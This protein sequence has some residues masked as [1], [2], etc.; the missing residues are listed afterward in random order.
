[1]KRLHKGVYVARPD[2]GWTQITPWVQDYTIDRGDVS[3]LGTE[4]AGVDSVVKTLR[5]TLVNEKNDTDWI[6][7]APED[8]QSDMNKDSEEAY[9]PLLS[10]MREII[11]YECITDLDEDPPEDYDDWTIMFHGFLGDDV[12]V[13]RDTVEI[14]ARDKAKRLQ[15]AYVIDRTE[16]RIVEEVVDAG[17]TWAETE[18]QEDPADV[19]EVIFEVGAGDLE[20]LK[21]IR[22]VV[23]RYIAMPEPDDA[24]E[25]SWDFY[26]LDE[27]DGTNWVHFDTGSFVGPQ[28]GAGVMTDIILPALTFIPY[29][30][31]AVFTTGIDYGYVSCNIH[32]NTIIEEEREVL[33]TYPKSEED[34]PVWDV[35]QDVIDDTLGPGEVIVYSPSGTS[36]TPINPDDFGEYIPMVYYPEDEDELWG[37]EYETV[38]NAIQSVATQYG[39]Y[40]G[41]MY[42]PNTS[43]EQLTLLLPPIDKDIASADHTFTWTD[44]LITQNDN[45]TDKHIRNYVKVHYVDTEGVEHYVDAINQESIDSFGKIAM[46]IELGYTKLIKTEDRA[47][48]FADQAL[49]DLSDYHAEVNITLPAMT[50]IDIF[51]GLVVTNPHTSTSPK[52]YAVESV[53][54]SRRADKFRTEVTCTGRVVARYRTWHE[55]E[56]RPE[57]EPPPEHGDSLLVPRPRLL[58]AEVTRRGLLIEIDRPRF[59]GWAYTAIYASPRYTSPILEPHPTSKVAEGRT[60][61][62][63]VEYGELLRTTYA[64]TAVNVHVN[65]Q[66]SAPSNRISV[67]LTSPINPPG[68]IVVSET[69]KPLGDGTWESSIHIAYTTPEH[70]WYDH[71][72]VSWKDLS[73]GDVQTSGVLQGSPN[74]STVYRIDSLPLGEYEVWIRTCDATGAGPFSDKE[75]ITIQGKQIP[76]DAIYFTPQFI[77]WGAEAIKLTY[78]ISSEADFEAYEVRQDLMFG[79]EMEE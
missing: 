23:T 43:T 62:F 65:G 1:M 71:S 59:I 14:T 2:D 47:Q 39:M 63:S 21:E 13:E 55:M 9:D 10:S 40:L 37:V 68:D 26:Y 78:A 17:T 69:G 66:Q 74:A 12:I 3:S 49:H 52:F 73:T 58:S 44:D 72:I 45:T 34:E 15:N 70:T 20:N 30:I 79:L 7:F 50:N 76:P 27:L 61:S 28:F 56:S 24:I 53:R 29:A 42:H 77:Q 6:S 5:M 38:W 54:H 46:E 57:R 16:M 32:Y 25:T 35:L 31:K 36:S 67:D 22:F 18:D 8:T 64:I 41:Y 4:N 51:D 60:T 75:S 11:I 19:I 33:R 48:N